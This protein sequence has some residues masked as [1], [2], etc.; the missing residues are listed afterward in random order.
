M[1]GSQLLEEVIGAMEFLQ[2][3]CFCGRYY[4]KNK[5][6]DVGFSRFDLRH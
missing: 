1:T 4:A 2:P 5:R 6:L 3:G